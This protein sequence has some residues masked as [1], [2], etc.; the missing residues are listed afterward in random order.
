MALDEPFSKLL[1][2]IPSTHTGIDHRRVFW[3]N[4]LGV[5]RGIQIP[6]REKKLQLVVGDGEIPV[7]EQHTLDAASPVR[8]QRLPFLLEAETHM[9][10]G[11]TK[12]KQVRAIMASKR[13]RRLTHV[14]I[15]VLVKRN[16]CRKLATP[17]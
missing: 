4:V 5:E 15:S 16:A 13:H 17:Q 3:Q 7:E 1:L 11:Y 8:A 14:Q 9:F 10:Q 2:N 6:F 12:T